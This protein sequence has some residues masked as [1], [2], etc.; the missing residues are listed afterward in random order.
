MTTK[1][2]PYNIAPDGKPEIFSSPDGERGKNLN[3][4]RFFEVWCK[5]MGDREGCEYTVNSIIN[6]ETGEVLYSCDSPKEKGA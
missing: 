2:R 5:I 3:L 6:K 4:Y 1:I